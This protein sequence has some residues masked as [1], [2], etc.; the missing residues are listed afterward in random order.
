M[1]RTIFTGILFFLLSFSLMAQGPQGQHPPQ[2]SA[3]RAK[4]TIDR[5]SETVKFTDKQK[6][7]LTPIFTKFFDDAKAQEA[8]R[9]P[10]KMKPLEKARDEKVEKALNNKTLFKQYQ[11]AMATMKAQRQQHQGGQPPQH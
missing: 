6:A 10:E 1:K 2:S 9:D 7:D 8:F 4:R 3:D 11:D 5:L